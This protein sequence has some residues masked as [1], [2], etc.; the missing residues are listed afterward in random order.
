MVHTTNEETIDPVSSCYDGSG[1]LSARKFGTPRPPRSASTVAFYGSHS[2][3]N[4]FHDVEIGMDVLSKRFSQT[5]IVV[6]ANKIVLAIN[7]LCLSMFQRCSFS[8]VCWCMCVC[9][10]MYVYYL[11]VLLVVC[12]CL[13]ICMHICKIFV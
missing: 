9:V 2:R 7:S 5:T 6:D 10:Y 11:V 4:P 13:C 12:L 1:E 3:C 8:C